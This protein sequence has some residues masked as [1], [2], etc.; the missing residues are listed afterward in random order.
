MGLLAAAFLSACGGSSPSSDS[1]GTTGPTGPTG[2]TGSTGPTGPTG[3]TG[4]TG[5]VAASRGVVTSVGTLVVNGIAFDASTAQIRIDD[6]PGRPENELKVGM[7]VTVKGSKDDA[8][9][10][11]K[12][13]E[14]ETHHVLRGK[15][16]DKGGSVLRVGGHEVEV[17]H[18]TEF[19]DRTARLALGVGRGAG[20]GP[21]PRAPPPATS[22]PRASRRS[23]AR[24]RTSR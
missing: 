6:N 13:T 12:A 14:I 22:G 23:P 16:D 15:V 11:G 10:T 3:P 19:E 9:G 8:A 24:R 5:A 2:P 18:G 4:T 21:R 17:E 1:T 20:P 7:V